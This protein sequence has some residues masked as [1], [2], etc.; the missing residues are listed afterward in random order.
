MVWDDALQTRV[1]GR[2]GWKASQPTVEGQTAGAFHGDI[3]ITSRYFPTENCPVGQAACQEAPNGGAPEVPDERLAKITFYVQTLAVPALR[4]VESSEVRQGA[5]LFV[6]AGCAACHSAAPRD[7][8]VI[9]C[10]PAARPG[11]LPVH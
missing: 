5:R 10:A 3:G 2:F 11:I 8:R 6:E 1:L 9:P 4:N 7:G